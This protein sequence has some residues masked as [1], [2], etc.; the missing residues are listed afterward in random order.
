MARTFGTDH[1]HAM[2]SR[3]VKDGIP[4]ALITQKLLVAEHRTSIESCVSGLSNTQSFQAEL[5]ERNLCHDNI[6]VAA[7]R[8]L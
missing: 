6:N 7:T 4:W 2:D 1:N 8:I 3:G 5:A